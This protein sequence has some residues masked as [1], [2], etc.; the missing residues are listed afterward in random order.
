MI[1]W[2]ALCRPKDYGGLG[3][4][5]T[6]MMNKALLCKWIYKLESG[7]DDL[8]CK[9]LRNKYCGDGGFFQTNSTG[10]SQFW[11][12]LHEVKSWMRVGSRYRIESGRSVFFWEDVWL[13][14]TPLKTQF[15][16]LYSICRDNDATVSQLYSEEG[17]N[18]ELRRSLRTQDIEEWENL[19]TML[20][21]VT[22]T[23]DRDMMIWTLNKTGKFTTK[24]LYREMVF[25]GVIDGRM[26]EILKLPIPAKI[27]IF[28]WM[29][30]KRRIQA[31]KQLKKMKW[32]G[33]PHCKL[34]G[35]I[36]D[37]NHLIF[38]CPP[39]KFWW[40]C[41]R[42]AFNWD[43]APN[44]CAEMLRRLK[45][46]G[47]HVNIPILCTMAAGSWAIW[48][49]RNDWVFHDKLL[50]DVIQL[51]YKAISF[52]QQWKPLAPTRLVAAMEEARGWLL[53]TVQDL[54][55]GGGGQQ[56]QPG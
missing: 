22:L 38:R 19:Q 5:D 4:I 10:G 6:R 39:K 53:A 51:P 21:G 8:C 50:L 25:G 55:E 52:L 36:E 20:E 27:R 1:R 26:L 47:N 41:V 23:E 40:C 30:V 56:L 31:A 49:T 13:G 34:C 44:S 16:Y 2:D 42:D 33:S 48:L 7:N 45:K 3:F 46:P 32:P 37:V 15:P 14:D 35:E 43:S 18:I 54:R 24:S 28:L 17:W 11:K 29:M 12:G 9:L